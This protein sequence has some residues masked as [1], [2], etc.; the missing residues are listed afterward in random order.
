LESQ[1]Q[2]TPDVRIDILKY[3]KLLFDYK[4]LITGFVF[5]ATV[6]AIVISLVMPKQ[7]ESEAVLFPSEKTGGANMGGLSGLG[8]M[9]GLELPRG[10][11]ATENEMLYSDIIKSHSF[12]KRI[13]RKEFPLNKSE[14]KKLFEIMGIDAG[15]SLNAF[16]SFYHSF[17]NAIEVKYNMTKNITTLKFHMADPGLT[18]IVLDTVIKELDLFNREMRKKKYTMQNEFL[19]KVE[20][21]AKVELDHA[22]ARLGYFRN[23]NKDF[24]PRLS[25]HLLNRLE[26][27][28]REVRIMEEK[29]ILVKKETELSRIN[30]EKN[31]PVINVLDSPLKPLTF[32]ISFVF[33]CGILI[34]REQWRRNS[35]RLKELFQ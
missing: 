21:T 4:F 13:F 19:Q 14:K 9:F 24:D 12:V 33:I 34:L 29:F 11:F 6:A 1:T 27:L 35:S 17:S 10:T 30:L 5:V 15:D 16:I 23:K 7:Y 2:K 32:L 20:K 8:K 22:V 31:M 26:E 18:K 25:P 3:I 28:E